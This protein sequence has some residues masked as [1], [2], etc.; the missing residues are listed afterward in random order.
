MNDF[1]APSSEARAGAGAPFRS[2]AP[3]LGNDL[4]PEGLQ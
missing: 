3:R 4:Q 2:S 1:A